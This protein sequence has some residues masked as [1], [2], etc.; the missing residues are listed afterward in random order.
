[1]CRIFF[2]DRLS[3]I[4]K[5]YRIAMTTKRLKTLEENMMYRIKHRKSDIF[6]RE[7]FGDLAGYD[8]V[9]RGLQRLVAK[10]LLAKIGYG[11]YARATTSPLSGKTIPK[12]SIHT[13]AKEALDRLNVEVLPTSYEVPITMKIQ[14]MFLLVV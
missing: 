8:Q 7:D 5:N 9:G 3:H 4:C 13:L 2:M 11:L 14:H 12:K 1:M 6:M 10:G